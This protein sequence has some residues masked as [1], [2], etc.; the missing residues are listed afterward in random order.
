[1]RFQKRS[2]PGG[3]HRNKVE[4]AVVMVHVPTGIRSEASER[5]CQHENLR[6]AL[7]RLRMN[8]AL[9]V[10]SEKL[11][12]GPGSSWSRYVRGARVWIG[13]RHPD[14]GCLVAECLDCLYHE[15]WHIRRA[16]QRL[17]CSS[18]QLIRILRFDRRAL[19]K[20]NQERRL[21]NLKPLR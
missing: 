4:S 6:V 2:G 12:T 7:L 20:T 5:R 21:R 18:S 3:Q 1:V 19:E 10:R 17:G 11:A 16:A 9:Q 15:D 8:L 14:A 13:A